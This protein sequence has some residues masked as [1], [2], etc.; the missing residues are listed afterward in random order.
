MVTRTSFVVKIVLF[1][2]RNGDENRSRRQK[3][4]FPTTKWRREPGSSSKLRFFQL[5]MAT[6]IGFVA[7]KWGFPPQNGDKNRFRRQKMGF[8]ASKWRRE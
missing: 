6:R 8:S 7:K 5:K 2:T 4:E 1:P 3:I